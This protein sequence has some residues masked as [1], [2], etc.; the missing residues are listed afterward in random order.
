MVKV[1]LPKASWKEDQAVMALWD[2]TKQVF[3]RLE[4]SQ[5]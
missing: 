5:L 2:G 1:E 3:E 4:M